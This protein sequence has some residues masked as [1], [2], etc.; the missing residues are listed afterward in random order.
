MRGGGHDASGGEVI[1]VDNASKTPVV[2]PERLANG[3]EVR[4]LRR[5]ENESAAGRN[6][7]VKVARGSWVVMLDD[8]SLTLDTGFVDVLRNTPADVAAV[9]AEIFL[10]NGKHEA[11]GLPEVFTG[12][13]VAIRRDVFLELGGYDASFV[14]YAEEYDLSARMILAGYRVVQDAR[15]RVLHHKVQEGRDMDAIVRHLVRNNGWVALRYAPDA[16]RSA[17]LNEAVMRYAEIAGKERAV[18]GYEK[19]LRELHQTA[20]QQPRRAMSEEQWARFTGLAEA[21]RELG[22]QRGVVAGKR[23]CVVGDGK[24]AWAVKQAAEELGGRLVNGEDEAQVLVV[25][26]MSP[27]RAADMAANVRERAGGK[28]VVRA[29]RA[30]GEGVGAG[31]AAT[32]IAA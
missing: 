14:Y 16:H 22:E 19:G 20:D 18:K 23:V 31:A 3:M 11:G 29:T 7:G 25:G 30:F 13:G 24:S 10:A 12:C 26:T 27:G 2:A 6:A 1:V 15:F 4:V 8:D 21:R 32:M 5:D 9:G 28:P 17:A